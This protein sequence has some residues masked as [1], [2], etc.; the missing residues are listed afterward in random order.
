[1]SKLRVHE[2]AKEL[3]VESKVLMA[4]LKAMGAKIISH[5]STLTDQQVTELR[6]A[7]GAPV[8]SAGTSAGGSAA[9]S[10]D[11][12]GKPRVVIRRRA[13][14]KEDAESLESAQVETEEA[15]T[16][17]VAPVVATAVVAEEAREPQPKPTLGEPAKVVVASAEPVKKV[18]E[19]V[20]AS[21]P[22]PV[23]QV[24]TRPPTPAKVEPAAEFDS[25][26]HPVPSA[27]A[28]VSR[29][30]EEPKTV[31]KESVP[32]E[33]VPEVVPVAPAP[34]AAP[35][36]PPPVDTATDVAKRRRE[37]GG[38]TIVR[39]A[40]PEEVE[41]LESANRSRQ[42][43][44]KEDHRGTRVT[45]LGLL[46]NRISSDAAAPAPAQQAAGGTPGAPQTAS[47][48]DEWGARRGN[49]VKDKKTLDDEEQLRRKAAAKA[50]RNQGAI[51]TR[52]LLQQAEILTSDEEVQQADFSGRT[53]YTPMSPRSKRDIKRRK[54]LKKTA[55]TTPRASYRVVNMGESITVGELAKQLA[56]KSSDLIKKL[57]TQGVMATINQPVDFDTATLLASEYQFEVKSN[58]QTVDDILKKAEVT[59]L[60]SRSPIVTVMGH[61]D[62]GK[63]SILDAIRS[64]DVAGGEAGGI[65]QHI[66][67]YS[68]EHNGEKIAFLDTPG[69]EAF[70]AMRARG[71]KVTDIV[72]L[73]VAADD[74]VMPQTIEAINHAKAA[75]VPL[76][77]AVNKID[78]P[79]INLD[80][81]Y[82]ELTEHGVQAEEWGGETQ[83]IKTSA[84][85]RKGIDE[86]LEAILLQAEVLDLKASANGQ[87]E[88][89]VIEAHLDKGRGPVA[90][91]MVQSGTLRPG[92]YIVAGTEYGRVRAMHD[93][94]NR[95]VAAAG[96]SEPVEI[97]GLS[98]VPRAGDQFNIVNDEKTA[99]EVAAFRTEQAR[100]A[101][102]TKSS[103]ASLADLL[104]KVKNE[105]IPEV[106][107]IVKADTQGSVEA[108]VD[109]ILKL[110]TDRVRNRIVHS[111][112]GGVNE[113]DVSLAQASGAV[114]VAFSV[115]AAR[116]LDETA[117]QAGVPIRYF[118]IIYEIVDAVKAL[119]VGKLP[120]IVSE[121]VLGRA[122]VRKPISVPKIGMIG[123]SAVLEG[124]ITRTS[125]CRLIR[126]DIVIYSGKLGS[127][128]RFKDDVK[129]VVQG[130]ECGIGIDG[131]NDLKEGDIIEA[132]ILEETSATL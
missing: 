1:M 115:R 67:A 132:Y 14:S 129:E 94:R 95:D 119:M 116:G 10:S 48:V 75:N 80:R 13:A 96:P 22:S 109:S 51:N 102:A 77:V 62:H 90:T 42:T 125:F 105:E 17:A 25:A 8:A 30:V 36:A 54:D 83:F 16:V 74:G 61:V 37:V 4:K 113:S 63:T 18:V 2:L 82:T 34:V 6:G 20:A 84:L 12:S 53:V 56:I 130:Y 69:H 99:R 122:E 59:D 50:R 106:P 87:A 19:Q 38:A 64:A 100:N 40:T 33:V 68:V 72:V 49:V 28:P 70:S 11:A 103:A 66:G 43:G 111:A 127:L 39:R 126:N 78:K 24:V 32:Q 52:L 57:M 91:V 107:I 45:G 21:I 76:I 110:N 26:A 44:R 98:G 123:G 5:Q 93:H 81:V 29:H 41:K 86:L 89:V 71:A 121:H 79:N 3:N 131:Y 73:V 27:P 118:S 128:R 15:P 124:K 9:V 104:A 120:P 46:S 60:E 92:D 31:T 117:E 88:G 7:L 108:I 65:T 58:I 47:D 55:I 97:I 101:Q 114:V 112:V 85:Q 23:A 35:T